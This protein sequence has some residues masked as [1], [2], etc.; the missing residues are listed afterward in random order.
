[1]QTTDLTSLG[2][3]LLA[4]LACATKRDLNR[5]TVVH[6]EQGQPIRFPSGAGKYS[7]YVTLLP[8][9]S[10]RWNLP[11]KCVLHDWNTS[12]CTWN[13]WL[14]TNGY[15]E[16]LPPPHPRNVNIPVPRGWET[17]TVTPAKGTRI[18]LRNPWVPGG[19]TFAEMPADYHSSF[20]ELHFFHTKTPT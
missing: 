19:W 18:A 9:N 20:P 2:F 3:A 12:S 13:L 11:E 17:R 1:M 5:L 16:T 14:L 8:H 7:A 6:V 15:G 4:D 10:W